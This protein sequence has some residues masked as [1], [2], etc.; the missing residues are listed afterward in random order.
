M[1]MVT[2]L[3]FSL[4]LYAEEMVMEKKPY[5]KLTVEEERVII[6]KGTETPYSGK[7]ND[8]FEKGT[9]HCKRCNARLYNSDDKFSSTCGWPSFDDEIPGTVLRQQDTDG[10]RTEILCANCGAHLGH[11]FE[12][13]GFTDKNIRHCVNSIA[14]V[15]VPD[16]ETKTAA[17]YFAGGCFWGVEYLFEQKDG[18]IS[19]TSGFMGGV[20]ADPSYQ[21][22]IRGDTGH[23][24]VVEVIYDPQKVDYEELVKFFF[25]I[26]DPTQVDGQG[27]DIGEQYLSAVFYETDAEKEIITRLIDILQNKGYDVITRVI[28]ASTFWKA[29]DY[30]Q[31]YYARKKQQPYCHVY[32]KKF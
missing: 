15:F 5:N 21:D 31:D 18:V 6:N 26:H 30:H 27:P 1:G 17:A 13:E 10:I 23:F 11:V 12:G 14:M 25:E 24:E 2:G 28:P 29:E 4:F 20:M 32:K 3:M 8:F 7:Y 9:Y 16:K 22:V 19:A